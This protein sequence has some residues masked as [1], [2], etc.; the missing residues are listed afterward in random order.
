MASK[1]GI[2]ISV[3]NYA[4]VDNFPKVKYANADADLMKTIFVNNLK[5]PEENICCY[6]NE[7]FLNETY[8]GELQ[9]FIKTLE[10]DSDLF[11]YYAG[12]GFFVDGENYLTAYDTSTLDL[13]KTSVN[14]EDLFLKT[15]KK[16]CA[17]R[18][19]AFIDACSQPQDEK[20]RGVNIRGIDLSTFES[21]LINRT[22][23]Y[24][25]FM[26]CSPHEKSYSS[27]KLEHG[28]WTWFLSKA[29]RG[30]K[31]ACDKEPCVTTYSL[32][33]YLYKS[34]IDY[35]KNI[36]ELPN[37]QTPYAIISSNSDEIILRLSD[38]ED[39]K[40][41]G[42]MNQRESFSFREECFGAK[43]LLFNS[44][45]LACYEKGIIV[46][47]GFEVNNFEAAREVCKE[48]IRMGFSLVS[49]WEEA[50]SKLRY[51][52]EA[53]EYGHEVDIPYYQQDEVIDSINCL[54][55]DI[56]DGW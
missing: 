22:Y 31:Y 33:N 6:N 54:I 42:E 39:K 5:I 41:I 49:D 43:G 47:D 15:F 40:E 7:M 50:I 24:T 45:S 28:I 35:R 13:V 32:K 26:S 12:H 52:C 44:C 8:E 4:S 56:P 2:I 51:Y 17:T 10:P 3:E 14:F 21:E 20:A 37:H 46:D 23:G 19:I 34:L 9:Y 48:V 30:D 11:F 25:I 29:L 53:F 27:N 18:C 1:Y 38:I 55:D 36:D 16:S